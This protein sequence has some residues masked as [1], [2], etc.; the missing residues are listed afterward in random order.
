[1]IETRSDIRKVVKKRERE[2]GRWVG[3]RQE[4]EERERQAGFLNLFPT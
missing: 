4:R 2:V 1:V 3:V